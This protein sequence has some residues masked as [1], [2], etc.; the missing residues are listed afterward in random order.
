MNLNQQIARLV[1]HLPVRRRMAGLPLLILVAT[2]VVPWSAYGVFTE[3]D[4]YSATYPTPGQVDWTVPG[5]FSTNAQFQ[6]S[7]GTPLGNPNRLHMLQNVDLKPGLAYSSTVSAP[8]GEVCDAL[9]YVWQPGCYDLYINGKK[10]NT[11][12]SWR[13]GYYLGE[14]PDAGTFTASFYIR[15]NTNALPDAVWSIKNAI[16]SCGA[17]Y[18][19]DKQTYSITADGKSQAIATVKNTSFPVTF[20][21][22]GNALGCSL[23][24]IANGAIFTPGTNTGTV[25]I[26]GETTDS[27]VCLVTNFW[28]DL[29]ECPK[30]CIACDRFT[31]DD[32]SVDL[33]IGTGPSSAG[34]GEAYMEAMSGAPSA[35][36]GSPQS[37]MPYFSRPDL[38]VTKN[39]LGWVRQASSLDRVVDINTN[40]AT[41]YVVNYYHPTDVSGIS[42]ND[43]TYTFSKAPYQSV[44]VNNVTNGG[45]NYV[46]V[47]D[48]T[49]PYPK[50]YYWETNGWTSVSGGGLKVATKLM[51]TNGNITTNVTTIAD[52][53]GHV[54]YQ[55]TEILQAL[56]SGQGQ[57]LLQSTIGSG[58]S[59]LV[60]SNSYNADGTV[61]QANHSDGSWDI[62]TYD[63]LG[64]Q[65]GHYSPFLNSAPT[66]NS[67][68][69]RYT[70]T[71][72]DT[73]L[74]TAA[75][76]DGSDPY[77]PR[78]IVNYVLTNEVGRSY[79]AMLP[80]GQLDIQCAKPG[81]AWNDSSNLV[82]VTQI[83]TDA[84]N[85]G[86]P[87]R[88]IHPD[89][90]LQ[91]FE[92]DY[93]TTCPLP[94]TDSSFNKTTVWTG[95]PDYNVQNVIDGTM[96]ETW[97]D[98]LQRKV[99]HRVTDIVSGVIIDQEK[100]YYDSL[101]HCTNTVYL[102][103]TSLQ[104]TYD[105]CNLESSVAP[106]GTVTSYGYD[107]LKR[108]ILT[109]Q[110]GIIVSNILDA[111]GNILGL[112][113]FGTDGSVI[114]NGLFTYDTAGRLMSST[115][116]LGNITTYTNYFDSTNQ[117]IKVTTY[118]DLSTRIE[119]YARDGVLVSI[120]GTAVLPVRYAYGVATDGGVQRVYRQEIK[121]NTNGT[122]TTEW[123]KTYLDMLGRTYKT[124]Y[125]SASGSPYNQ[126]FY[127]NYG[128][129]VAQCDPDG[130][131][132]LYQYNAKGQVAYVAQDMNTNG[133]IDFAGPDRITYTVSDVVSNGYNLY[134]NRT[135][136]YVWS[137]NGVN[138]SNLLS[139]VESSVDGLQ[140]WQITWNNGLG[141][142]NYSRTSFV[143]A[144][145][146][147]VYMSVA[148]N[149][150]ST[151]STRQY[152]RLVSTVGFDANGQ[153]LGQTTYGYDTHGRQNA[154]TDARSGTT[155]Y[156]FNNNDRIVAA[157]SPSP[158]GMQAGELTTNILDSLG[159][160]VRTLLSDSTSVTNAYYT[161]GLL[162]ATYGSHE[163][164]V[165][166]S[167]DY[168]G[169]M[170]TMTTWTNFATS[171]GAAVTIWNYDVYRGF[172]TNKAYA[173]SVG[174]VY[175]YSAAGR[176]ISR[177]WARGTTI[178][179]AYDNSGST[180][181]VS[182][183]DS[184]SGITNGYDRLGRQI[185]VTNGSIVCNWTY[186][187]L[188]ETLT[189]AYTGGPL[190]GLT[191]TN[192]Y[193]ALLRRTNLSLLS[194]SGQVL[195]FTKY[196]YDA[197]SRLSTVGDGT[198]IAIYTYLPN[199]SLVGAMA[200]Q[201]NGQTVMSTSKQYDLLNRLTSIASLG[202]TN[203]GTFKYGYN[204]A[205][206]RMVVTNT[207][208]SY[209]SYQYDSLG[210]INS[211]KKYWADGTPVAGQQFTYN[212]DNIGNRTQAQFDG[213][214]TGSNLRTAS[215]TVNNLNEYTSRTVPGYVEVFGLAN[216]NATVT[217]NLQRAYR[218]GS[219]FADE[220]SVTNTSAPIYLSL[221]NL[222]VLNNGT[223]ADI[224]STNNGNI[225][226]PQTPESFG[227]DA[228]GN[229]TN[230]GRFSL[231][232][233]AENRV[234]SLVSPSTVPTAAKR[235]I[236]CVYD[237]SGRRIQKIVST[238]NGSA[239]VPVST[240]RFVYNGWNLVGILDGGNNLLYSFQWGKDVS[241]SMQTAGGV[242]GLVGISYHGSAIT[243]CFPAYDGN[244]NVMALIN[245]ADG[246]IAANYDYGPFGEVLRATG[247]MA[248]L[249][250]FRFSTRYTDNESD[251]LYYGYRYYN[252]SA[253][254]WLSRDRIEEN[255][256]INL[257]GLLGNDSV[258][259]VDWFGLYSVSGNTA[260]GYQVLD[261]NMTGANAYPAIGI[262][263][264]PE[265]RSYTTTTYMVPD[266]PGLPPTTRVTVNNNN[267]NLM[268]QGA[269]YVNSM[270]ITEP[271]GGLFLWVGPANQMGQLPTGEGEY[272][273]YDPF[274]ARQDAE[275]AQEAQAML[276][277]SAD[278]LAA[279]SAL[280]SGGTSLELMGCKGVEKEG[281]PGIPQP[282]LDRLKARLNGLSDRNGQVLNVRAFG[283]RTR[284][285]YGPDSDFD[286]A[287]TVDD[288]TAFQTPRH[289]EIY[290][291]IRQDFLDETGVRLDLNMANWGDIGAK[292]LYKSSDLVPFP[293]AVDNLIASPNNSLLLK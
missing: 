229:M 291:S 63:S 121:Q 75:G 278:L 39:S 106:D 18:A 191:I 153:Q 266:G 128:Q 42:T 64:R 254:R 213:D 6:W 101:N 176:L 247:P 52:G 192:G 148:P 132:R 187:N 225:L 29:K 50:D 205:N 93:G 242:G 77:I 249:N 230:N 117:L 59:A 61:A 155:T 260:I 84:L 203:Y 215:Y 72:Y 224:V 156:Y 199:S 23:T 178:T 12:P 257:Y 37:I 86:K 92:Y 231:S 200:F 34:D 32:D 10:N 173:N 165:Q 185:V 41:S 67:T 262:A 248:K 202:M 182:Y 120:S 79:T 288:S 55:K 252:P 5:I 179:Y 223:N 65:I 161:N 174:S 232:W 147:M 189:E 228:D 19:I 40:S 30:S 38:Q 95:A 195:A 47:T 208:A 274:K 226:L 113:R 292:T 183:S 149:G 275:Q 138:S 239:Y 131:T 97:T 245:V 53:S 85:I 255:G 263:V 281:F 235:K 17:G 186:N 219:Y 130:V 241:G 265:M 282:S 269:V 181:T 118:P 256:G 237:W 135:Q 194:G 91:D 169:R 104:Q 43:G 293:D 184:T 144:S 193:D 240:N 11:S 143:P 163:Y 46:E 175:G 273:P 188:G 145:G 54:A 98:Y 60:E 164:P 154:M 227:Y 214:A 27:N 102:N 210:Q 68:L 190:S 83:F 49:V 100:Y 218:Y 56:S 25:E 82:T 81:A 167:Y 31:A 201:H 74:V 290:Q 76:D 212:F 268:P 108:R 140:S 284:G 36:I 271:T 109:A 136:T 204:T 270:A 22:I 170:K 58:P 166:Y 151:V 259:A 48:S 158:D 142:T 125:S 246:S 264:V 261:S 112:V 244:G 69:C 236:D 4:L 238:N 129:L 28:F 279:L 78:M 196:A 88:I 276:N 8:S 15:P 206:Q 3:L 243:N 90:T 16:G 180:A 7:C 168:S 272:I 139:T 124:L 33:S 198:N 233:D 286:V 115:D 137:T 141:L 171:T 220:L 209:W 177:S 24:P 133:V 197:A 13:D 126:S 87:A 66:T 119:T 280:E 258:N 123:T 287:V 111:N 96:D 116:G 146:Q 110:N 71:S 172:L 285:D 283:G 44:L 21:L 35:A 26:Y 73:N 51:Y 162:Q 45:S 103:R 159:R 89:G 122:D 234:L 217:V 277:I 211:G 107:A 1:D 114:T 80:A 157:L 216:S 250:P 57:N 221:T 160:V 289:K 99:L 253:G 105:C 14:G 9:L 251:L 207:D 267:A 70:A 152:G 150:S 94:G 127:N 20:H 62:Y 222:A 134:A 2:L